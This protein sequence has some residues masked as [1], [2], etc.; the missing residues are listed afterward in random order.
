MP[1]A[2]TQ[3]VTDT[4]LVQALHTSLATTLELA[5]RAK[6]AHWNVRGPRFS[7]LHERFDLVH[8]AAMGW[9]DGLAERSAQLG[10]AVDGSPATI[11]SLSIL[12]T[13]EGEEGRERTYLEGLSTA[14]RDLSAQLQQAVQ[15]AERGGDP[16]TADLFTEV[17][18]GVDAER[19][20]TE[21]HLDG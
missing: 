1:S 15:V 14:M 8:A 11:A 3:S 13:P 2:S 18:R 17:L 19:W 21:A 9:S 10:H 12:R 6:Q 5:L 20:M 16:A 4:S 7:L